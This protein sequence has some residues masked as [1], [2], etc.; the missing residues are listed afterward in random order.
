MA[1]ARRKKSLLATDMPAC[2]S[3]TA[4][5]DANHQTSQAHWDNLKIAR[6]WNPKNSACTDALGVILLPNVCN[7]VVV[8]SGGGRS[9]VPS[10]RPATVPIRPGRAAGLPCR[11]IGC[12][13][14]RGRRGWSRGG[15]RGDAVGLPG[16]AASLRRSIK[17]VYANYLDAESRSVAR[18]WA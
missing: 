5:K 3:V 2:Q 1:W 9:F 17:A 6:Q 11:G 10:P 4:K 15:A 16:G 7:E 13:E 8:G 14:E 18:S 12:R